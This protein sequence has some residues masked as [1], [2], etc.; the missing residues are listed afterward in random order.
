MQGKYFL[1]WTWV[2]FSSFWISDRHSAKA[3]YLLGSLKESGHGGALSDYQL[4]NRI[5]MKDRVLAL[6]K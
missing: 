1:G 5:S 3:D 2:L 4:I 6:R